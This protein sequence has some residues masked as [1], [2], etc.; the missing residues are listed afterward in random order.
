MRLPDDD[1]PAQPPGQRP[2]MD[3]YEFNTWEFWNERTY[4]KARAKSPCED[5]TLAFSDEMV[6]MGLCDGIPTVVLKSKSK[7]TSSGEHLS[8]SEAQEL[9][10]STESDAEKAARSEVHSVAWT[11]ER[12]AWMSRMM[13]RR[14]ADP[15]WRLKHGKVCRE[16][17]CKGKV[18]SNGL[19][20][21]H[22]VAWLRRKAKEHE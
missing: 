3:D 22:H 12:R 16:E 10:Y 19:C 15:E 8:R 11:P 6:S 20:N 7:G 14:N 4:P 18:R 5:C 13:K 21:K 1:L 2:C 17:G 9:R